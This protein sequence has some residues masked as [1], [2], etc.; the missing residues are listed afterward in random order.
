MR[1]QDALGPPLRQAALVLVR[2]ADAGKI[3]D[4]DL[5]AARTEEPCATHMRRGLQEG[6]EHA[7][8]RQEFEAGGLDS[9]RAGLPMRDEPAFDDPRH[10]AVA[11]QLAS[12]EE[13]SRAG[14]DNQ[15]FLEVGAGSAHCPT[16]LGKDDHEANTY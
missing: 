15:N 2:T 14:A 5:L 7:G 10:D 1:E 9:G 3:A 6:R 12:C 4:A 16:L 11:G 8:A 13:A